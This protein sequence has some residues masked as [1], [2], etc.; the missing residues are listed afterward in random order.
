LIDSLGVPTLT[1]WIAADL[2]EFDNPNFVGRCGT[3]A[4]RGANFAVQN[5]DL[6]VSIG[7]RLDFSITGFNR[8]QFARAA[9]VVVI[10]ID[11]AEIAKLGELP[12]LG[13]VADAGDFIDAL[14]QRLS[15][16]RLAIDDWRRRCE[17]WKT[18]YPVVLPEY[19]AQTDSVNTYVFAETLCDEMS[20]GDVL[21]PAS[22]GAAL[23]TFWLAA[24]LK[25]GQRSLPTGSL[26]AM[27]YGLPAAVGGCLGAG[28]Q[29]TVSAS[30][31]ADQVVCPQ[32][33]RLCLHPGIAVRLLRR[34]HRRGREL[35]TDVA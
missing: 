2:L 12:S 30:R 21:V 14:L 9:D 28:S 29:R 26:G 33:R 34:A 32:Q 19:R 8:S 4:P 27:G 18:A 11:P 23:D 20:E 1:T 5:A 35:W 6:V 25:R 13:V 17:H 22:S 24:R 15:G 31:A 16:D 7:C 10:D 3:A